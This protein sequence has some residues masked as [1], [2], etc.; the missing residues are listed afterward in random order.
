MS[1]EQS[2]G[3]DN[4]VETGTDWFVDATAET[5]VELCLH[6]QVGK[7][8]PIYPGA[9][10]LDVVGPDLG[11][12]RRL[13]PPNGAKPKWAR[14]GLQL[15]RTPEPHR[16]L[17]GAGAQP[18]GFGD[19][20]CPFGITS[21]T[22]SGP[23]QR[24]PNAGIQPVMLTPDQFAFELPT[25]AHLSSSEGSDPTRA[26]KAEL[27]D[28]VAC[29]QLEVEALTFGP[30]GHS[31]LGG[32]TSPVRSKPVVFT[33]TK[34]PKLAGVTSWGH[35]FDTIAQSNGWD[36]ATAALQLLSDLEGD[37]L[38]VA[39]LVPEARGSDGT[40]WVTGSLSGLSTSV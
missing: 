10:C 5:E 21:P 9:V 35:I 23:A 12:Q 40:L 32:P 28:T 2:D 17:P 16:Q 38:H 24:R 29:L 13:E 30:L 19:G 33:S 4:V 8:I 1:R 34:V 37:A 36:D 39:L 22:Y 18:I 14:H 6:L 7:D 26:P 11:M 3:E 25:L 31:T 27:M 20:R 15:P